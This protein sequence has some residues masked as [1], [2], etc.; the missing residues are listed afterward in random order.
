M[1]CSM[2][3]SFLR[4]GSTADY[5]GLPIDTFADR[6][7]D[8]SMAYCAET[9]CHVSSCFS[10]SLVPPAN[11]RCHIA[12]GILGSLAAVDDSRAGGLHNRLR[13]VYNPSRPSSSL[14]AP[15]LE[16]GRGISAFC[17]ALQCRCVGVGIHNGFPSKFPL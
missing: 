15:P 12:H 16:E 6:D 5:V 17:D 10:A 2:Y 8:V 3:G 9:M 7:A 4:I 13:D 14:P 11:W 1:H